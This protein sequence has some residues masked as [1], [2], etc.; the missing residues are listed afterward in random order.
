[1]IT[2]SIIILFLL[3]VVAII[4]YFFKKI[5]SILLTAMI[6]LVVMVNMS[7]V[8]FG[9]IHISFGI[10]AFIFAYLL[11]EA[12]FFGGIGD[13]KVITIIGMMIS[14]IPMMFVF[15]ILTM[16]FGLFWKILWKIRFKGQEIKEIPFIPSLFI[17]YLII[18]IFGGII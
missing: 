15:I 8:T 7:E 9:M 2:L 12:D 5:P 14:S 10:I 4:D 16:T 6:F 1:M 11:Y 17:V 3:G 13:L 18:Y